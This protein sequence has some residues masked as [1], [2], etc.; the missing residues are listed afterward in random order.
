MVEKK[1]GRIRFL[2][3][4]QNTFIILQ[5]NV[6]SDYNH[7]QTIISRQQTINNRFKVLHLLNFA[8]SIAERQQTT[9]TNTLLT[10]K[11]LQ[12]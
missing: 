4:K 10:F 8:V 12:T 7:L 5:I 9:V 11:N 1:G 2:S 3:K 6:L